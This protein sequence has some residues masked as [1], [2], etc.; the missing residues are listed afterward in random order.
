RE[1]I[2]ERGKS[3]VAERRN[4][5]ARELAGWVLHRRSPISKQRIRPRSRGDQVESADAPRLGFERQRI[6]QRDSA[7]LSVRK[8]SRSFTKD[9]MNPFDVKAALDRKSTRLNSSH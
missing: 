7:Q 6:I 5:R 4:S 9:R 2:Q 3:H 1:V 8:S